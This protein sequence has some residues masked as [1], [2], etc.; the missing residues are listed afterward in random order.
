MEEWWVWEGLMIVEVEVEEHGRCR[1]SN[2]GVMRWVH[3][4]E[5]VAHAIA[6]EAKAMGYPVSVA[7]CKEARAADAVKA[8][9]LPELA[10][11]HRVVL[12]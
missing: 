5:V 11:V 7:R 8:R 3:S 1:I 12:R 10:P 6:E 4:G 9:E 2:G